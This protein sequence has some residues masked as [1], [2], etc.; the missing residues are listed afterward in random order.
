MPNQQQHQQPPPVVAVTTL[1]SRSPFNSPLSQQQRKRNSQGEVLTILTHNQIGKSSI[2]ISKTVR[3]DI[4]L[5]GDGDELNNDNF[6]VTFGGAAAARRNQQQQKQ[7]N[8]S[9]AAA[10]KLTTAVKNSFLARDKSYLSKLSSYWNK[11]PVNL[12]KAGKVASGMRK[13]S[14]MMVFTT[15][16]ISNDQSNDFLVE[17]ESQSEVSFLVVM[18]YIIFW[19]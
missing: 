17:N 18:K 15:V 7:Q 13:T 5:D 3:Q 11:N 2:T 4:M 16:D 19:G 14:N 8:N 6:G 10:S 9:P 12:E 1:A